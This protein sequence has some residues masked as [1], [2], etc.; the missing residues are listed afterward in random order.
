MQDKLFL[1]HF[2]YFI[3]TNEELIRL[4]SNTSHSFL[5]IPINPDK[6]KRFYVLETVVSNH[7][8]M[9]RIKMFQSNVQTGMTRI[10]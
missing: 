4:M 2:K 6:N 10:Y 3:Q 8:R 5:V 9:G 1:L 7:H